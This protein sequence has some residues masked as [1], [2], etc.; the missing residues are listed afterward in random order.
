M[1]NTKDK[2]IERPWDNLEFYKENRKKQDLI[3]RKKR[4]IRD[5]NIKMKKAQRKAKILEALQVGL[6]IAFGII[7]II[8]ISKGWASDMHPE[9]FQ[10]MIERG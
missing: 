4:L 6:L 7:T 1:K 9:V 10:R 8:L 5:I 2:Q 3:R